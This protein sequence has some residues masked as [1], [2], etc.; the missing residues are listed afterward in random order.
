[1]TARRA[2]RRQGAGV[3]REGSKGGPAKYKRAT[4][5]PFYQLTQRMEVG[6]GAATTTVAAAEHRRGPHVARELTVL[7]R[8]AMQARWD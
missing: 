5:K 1:M 8:L 3:G 6:V 4:A 2:E 7:L